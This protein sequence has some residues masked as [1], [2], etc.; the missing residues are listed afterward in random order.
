MKAN[1]A[2]GD[3]P[4]V[5]GYAETRHR[6]KSW[7]KERRAIAR[8]EA[9]KLGL[10]IRF[11]VT[12]LTHG[13]PEWL[14]DSLY[15]ARGQAENLIK[16]HKSQ[17]ASDRTSCRSAVANQVR[18]VL[19]KR[20]NVIEAEAVANAV[21]E[22]ARTSPDM[23]LGVVT[24]STVQRDVIG[25]LLE[26]KR[27]TDD[28]LD[29]FLHEGSHE[30][31]FVKNLENVQGDERDVILISVGYGPRTAGARLDSMSF[32]PVSA[33]GGERRLNVLFN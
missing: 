31:V 20:V 12:S 25:D 23:T 27:R 17:L 6:A 22:H 19:H 10:D 15:C 29:D 5:R 8:I 7:S 2:Q 30:D 11:I 32:G 21:A 33:E 24:F 3:K 16:L 4:V 14:Y 28:A 18:L 26:Q 9:T 1:R 13:S